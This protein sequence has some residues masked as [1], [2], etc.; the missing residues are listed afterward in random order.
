MPEQ[1]PALQS[2]HWPTEMQVEFTTSPDFT[3][4]AAAVFDLTG[5]SG[6]NPAA[7]QLNTPL[8]FIHDVSGSLSGWPPHFIRIN[9]WPGFFERP[10]LEATARDEIKDT[11]EK[12]I[13]LLG[14]KPEWTPD[15]PGFVSAR[16]LAAIINEAFLALE[17][18][19]SSKE[20]I[21]TAMQ[22][23]TNYPMGP[24]AWADKIGLKHIYSLLQQMAEK[25]ARYQPANLL[26]K[27]AGY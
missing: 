26:K 27:E 25:D 4:T 16:V 15:I 6:N 22:L 1:L 18:G 23:G 19:V 2:V 12:F 3:A 17:E 24:F 9:A 21:D 20:D 5:Q 13:H 8:V 7:F 10:L 14:K 11:A